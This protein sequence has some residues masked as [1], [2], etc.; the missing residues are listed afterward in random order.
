M[1]GSWTG[2]ALDVQAANKGVKVDAAEHGAP[3]LEWHGTLCYY[4]VCHFGAKFSALVAETWRNAYTPPAR[5][6]QHG[7]AQSL[8]LRRR[9]ARSS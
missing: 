8:A 7:T 9:L 3:L 1:H 2:I 4:R 6:T 5:H